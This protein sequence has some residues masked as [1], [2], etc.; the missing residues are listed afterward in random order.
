MHG[1][2]FQKLFSRMVFFSLSFLI[3]FLVISNYV[4]VS[5]VYTNLVQ[6]SRAFLKCSIV[7][8]G[9]LKLFV[10]CKL[11][12][13]LELIRVMWSGSFTCRR[14]SG[15][16]EY[17]GCPNG[18]SALLAHWEGH[19]RSSHKA[20][21]HEAKHVCVCGCTYI[22]MHVSLYVMYMNSYIHNIMYGCMHM[23]LCSVDAQ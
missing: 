3:C 18:C 23:T 8:L 17:W 12:H 20:S 1:T 11:L 7:V 16:F 4:E 19:G 10:V 15:S 21:A 9:V 5:L 6:L 13:F 14:S 2:R 22:H